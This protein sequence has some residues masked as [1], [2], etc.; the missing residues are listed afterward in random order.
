LKGQ[1]NTGRTHLMD[2]MP[3][4]FSQ[5]L[6]GWS[7]QLKAVEKSIISSSKEVAQLPQGGTAIGTGINAHKDFGKYLLLRFQN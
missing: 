4:D 3:I 2:A 6:S 7:A 5:E 1:V